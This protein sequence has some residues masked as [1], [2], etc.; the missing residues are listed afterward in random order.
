M[1]TF[2]RFSRL[3][4][5]L[6]AYL[7]TN[8]FLV[9]FYT[10]YVF[11]NVI[12][13]FLGS[14]AE[15]KN[16]TQL[17]QEQPF[18]LTMRWYVSMARGTGFILN[19]N[20]ALVIFLAAKLFFTWLRDTPLNLILPIDKAFPAIHIL[21]GYVIAIS[22]VIH[23]VF[24]MVW[25]THW[26]MWNSGLWGITQSTVTGWVLLV[27]FAVML[28]FAHS[29]IRSRHFRAF[30]RVHIIGAALFFALLIFHGMYNQRPES[31]KYIAPALIIYF[32]DRAIRKG[33]V[34]TTDLH[35]SHDNYTFKD[36]DILQL[37][38][39]KPFPYQPG[40][41][42]EIKIP[43]INNEWHPFTIASSPHEEYMSFFIKKLG[44]WTDVIHRKFQER[45]FED[46]ADSLLVQVRG[47]FGAPCQ[48][49]SSTYDR[50]VLISGGIG[51][52][53]FSSI[54]KYL[55]H[56]Q[57][58][59]P[60]NQTARP[61]SVP[62][63]IQKRLDQAIATL[64]DI[65][66][67]E[68]FD[69]QS[70]VSHTTVSENLESESR[71]I[72]VSNML[73]LTAT[74]NQGDSFD[75]DNRRG[76]I[77]D[78]GYKARKI[79]DEESSIMDPEQGIDLGSRR[80]RISQLRSRRGDCQRRA[81][82]DHRRSR[83]LSFLHTTRVSMFLLLTLIVRIF[84]ISLASILGFQYYNI[85]ETVTQGTGQWFSR[86]DT[87]LGLVFVLIL[88]LTILLEISFMG[89]R[90]FKTA[91]RI[92]DFFV[93][94][95]VTIACSALQ[96]HRW[97]SGQPWG[98]ALVL[99][100]YIM[101]IPVMFFLLSYRMYRTIGSRKLLSDRVGRCARHRRIPEVDF[102][103]AV[104]NSVDDAWLRTELIPLTVSPAATLRLHRYVTREKVQEGTEKGLRTREGRPDWDTLFTSIS[105][106][107]PSDSVVGIFFCGPPPMGAAVKRSMQYAEQ[108]THLR[109]AYLAGDERA[110][111]SDI[112]IG[113][114][115]LALLKERG[116][117]VRFVFREENF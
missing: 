68:E 112:A 99:V 88:P 9:L 89:L 14:V 54:C 28:V 24:H 60:Q 110:V 46:E 73:R 1:V 75:E 37:R 30:Y 85:P 33:K 94:L 42:A 55:Q 96:L 11:G 17:G 91:G 38:I 53:P 19:V 72:Y 35:I 16:Q 83:V 45:L 2:H 5:S 84:L 59:Q 113:R 4:A 3:S 58:T 107:T 36:N 66:I 20:S 43:S 64:Y 103:W 61:R 69:S 101:F 47:P 109:A 67:A 102:I 93:F 22:I 78:P 86:V 70:T 29:S 25:V 77:D 41:Y 100:H 40:Q 62:R 18:R 74:N 105:R 49:A 12:L 56:L 79:S 32:I 90:Y 7:S 71:R 98:L 97:I 8:A 106:K 108:V 48:H 31:Y 63:S 92:I 115:E 44:D 52:T 26:N 117:N 39:Q 76:R 10:L 23:A 95:P 6:E 111:M 82:L 116:G 27:I 21:S 114:E 34:S 104:N 13:F 87:I 81:K 65:E 15:F 50:V 57:T 80:S 51:A